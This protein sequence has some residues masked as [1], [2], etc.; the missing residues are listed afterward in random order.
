V[1]DRQSCTFQQ[2]FEFKRTH[3]HIRIK[4]AATSTEGS[5]FLATLIGRSA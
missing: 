2:A 4:L 5:P 3:R 1:I